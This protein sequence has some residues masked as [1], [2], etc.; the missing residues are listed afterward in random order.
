ME[1]INHE[2]KTVEN[3]ELLEWETPEVFQTV[4]LDSPPL[5]FAHSNCG[6]CY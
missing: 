6:T 4:I 5:D 1:T 2:E 3:E